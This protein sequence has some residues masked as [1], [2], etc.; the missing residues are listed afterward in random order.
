M[1]VGLSLRHSEIPTKRP[2]LRRGGAPADN[3]EVACGVT[4]RPFH[5]KRCVPVSRLPTPR[6]CSASSGRAGLA[7]HTPAR[8]RTR[9]RRAFQRDMTG[10]PSAPAMRRAD[11]NKQLQDAQATKDRAGSRPV[12]QASPSP[13]G[14]T[15]GSRVHSTSVIPSHSDDRPPRSDCVSRETPSRSRRVPSLNLEPPTE[16]REPTPPTRPTSGNRWRRAP[17]A[18]SHRPRSDVSRETPITK[19]VRDLHFGR[20]APRAGVRAWPDIITS[21]SVPTGS[22]G[23]ARPAFRTRP[24]K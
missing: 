7:G 16:L 21:E 9:A 4:D 3:P 8:A 1:P 18:W 20:Y 24:I 23:R 11:E 22:S 19:E 17:S 6:S 2:P 13:P 12:L 5:V 15:S 14:R 10:P